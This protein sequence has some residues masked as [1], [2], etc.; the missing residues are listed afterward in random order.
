MNGTTLYNGPS[1]FN[2]KPIVVVATGLKRASSNSKTGSMI[3][4]Y[5]LSAENDKPSDAVF[6]TGRSSS[7]CGDCKHDQ[8]NTCY[9]N[10]GQGANA[11]YGGW[12]RG[13]YPTYDVK[14]H[15]EIFKDK[16]VRI[17]TYGDPAMVPMKVWKPILKQAK[18]HTAYTHQWD[19]TWAQDYKSF[20]MASV[21]TKN[22]HDKAKSMGW[23]T[24]RV[25]PESEVE[26]KPFK[27]ETVCPA[28]EEMNKRKKCEDCMLC[29]GGD[30][31][32]DVV[33]AVHGTGYKS[34]RFNEIMAEI[35]RSA[36]YDKLIPLKIQGRPHAEKSALQ[37]VK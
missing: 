27:R 32:V 37:G 29:H 11:V 24:F 6:K 26:N 35:N 20:C 23:R 30:S 10:V 12:Q 34:K 16:L 13:I 25:R 14:K 28:S 17:G 19:K 18:N 15:G 4:V 3:Q 7:C 33:I 31:K 5:I 21:D 8:W 2:G 22:E 1:N 36:S 9:V